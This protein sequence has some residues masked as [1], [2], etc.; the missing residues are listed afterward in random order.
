MVAVAIY[1]GKRR[2]RRACKWNAASF[3]DVD[4]TCFVFVEGKKQK[5]NKQIMTAVLCQVELPPLMM[6]QQLLAATTE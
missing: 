3:M 2:K 6:L 4:R 1:F 5:R